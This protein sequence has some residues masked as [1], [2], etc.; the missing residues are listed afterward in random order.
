MMSPISVAQYLEPGSVT[1]DLLLIDEASQVSPVD[2]LGA[3]ARAARWSS[4]GTTSSFHRRDSSA[5]CSTTDESPDDDGDLNAGDLES[6]LGLCVA[7]GMSQRMLRWHYRSRHH[8]LI[9]VS[10]REFYENHLFVVPSPTTITAMHGLHFRLVKDGVFD[11]GK[12]GDQP[13]GGEG[14]RRGGHRACEAISQEI[15]GGRGVLGVPARRDP[16]RA[17]GLAASARRAGRRSSRRGA[18]EPFFVK[19]LE[20][21]QGDERDVI[22]I[23][24]GYARDASGYMAMNFGP[25]SSQGGE[26]R[27]NVL[28]SRARE[29]CEVFSSITADDIDLQRGE[30]AGSGAS[31]RFS[32]TP[33][34]AILDCAGPTGGDYDSDFERQVAVALKGLGYEVHRQVGTAGFI[35]DLAVVD[36]AQARALPA[37]DRVRRGDLSFLARRPAIGTG[38][39]RAVLRDRG[40]RIHRVWSTDWFHRPEEQLRKVVDAIEKAKMEADIDEKEELEASDQL[41]VEVDIEREEPVEALNGETVTWAV[42]YVEADFEVPSATAIHE[43]PLTELVRIVARVVEIEGPIHRDEIAR[44][45]TTLW[46]L[47]RTGGRIVETIGRAIDSGLQAG[48]L[49][50]HTGFISRSGQGQVPVRDRSEVASANLK[51]PEMIPPLEIRQAVLHLV[52]DHLGLRWAEATVLVARTLG[53]KATSSKLRE[54]IEKVL[55]GMTQEGAVEVRDEKVF[56][57]T[58]SEIRAS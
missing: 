24:V 15:A 7:Q 58:L 28:I 52:A 37:G 2:A 57:A 44:R 36:S 49:K 14:D 29:R 47:Q 54:V 10:N 12:T 20:N 5:R 32:V 51:R 26:R 18:P 23:S 53:F 40:W 25:L 55:Q 6:I 1:F 43:T 21:I 41:P 4:S 34:R 27:L 48:L 9:A 30:V 42:P 33:P 3:M 35:I 31:R 50:V 46:G 19:N 17:G 22:F 13:G 16:R 11:R 38:C 45:I 39:V 56:L 8:S